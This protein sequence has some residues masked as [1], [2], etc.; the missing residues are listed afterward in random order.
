MSPADYSYFW[1][2]NQH[3]HSKKKWLGPG[4]A[5]CHGR[6]AGRR[7]A[8]LGCGTRA[9][10]AS[11]ARVSATQQESRQLSRP[12]PGD[13]APPDG[14]SPGSPGVLFPMSGGAAGWMQERSR[15]CQTLGMLPSS[16]VTFQ[17]L[18]SQFPYLLNVRSDAPPRALV[19]PERDGGAQR[20]CR[21]PT[22]I[23]VSRA[24]PPTT[25]SAKLP[26][27]EAEHPARVLLEP[28]TP[29]CL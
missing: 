27:R 12:N 9:S 21:V 1:F 23:T 14:P 25:L 2:H 8:L 17:P 6:G 22:G 19:H 5:G 28:E 24:R 7:W 11:S 16:C 15:R 18:G 20:P 3:C 4:H 13:R 29:S 26:F 10:S